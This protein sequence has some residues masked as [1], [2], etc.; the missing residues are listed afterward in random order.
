LTDNGVTSQQ[1]FWTIPLSCEQTI[2]ALNA[3]WQTLL[4]GPIGNAADGFSFNVGRNVGFPVA[5]EEGGNNGLSVTVDTFDNGGAEVGIEVR[6]NG[7]QLGFTR[8]PP[9]NIHGPA[10]LEKNV[11]VNA[12]VAVSASGF[13]T[14]NYDTY[15]VGAQ[16]PNY[17]GI[18][19]NQYVFAARTGGAA[20][21]AWIDNV[22]IDN[23]VPVKLTIRRNADGSIDVSWTGAGHLEESSSL[24]SASWSSVALTSPYHVAA[25]TGMRF[26]RVVNP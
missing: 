8:V 7:V 13:V 6:W 11:F 4:N 10:E 25:P 15:S 2:K 9:G 3:S 14:F 17:S 19:A 18:V 26:Y 5:A 20:E 22:C 21:D 23:S 24:S 12:N 16:I 1:N